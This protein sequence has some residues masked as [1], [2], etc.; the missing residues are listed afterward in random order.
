[1]QTFIARLLLWKLI[2]TEI[3]VKPI[4]KVT[5]LQNL[6]NFSSQMALT[7]LLAVLIANLDRILVLKLLPSEDFGRYSLSLTA[8]GFLQLAIQPFYRSFFPKFSELYAKNEIDEL[9]NEYFFSNK[10]L[11]FSLIALSSIFFF[12]AHDL[13]NLWL[14]KVDINLVNTFRFLIIGM[15]LSGLG[16]LPAAFQQAIG[17]PHLHVK[18]MILALICGIPITVIFINLF[19]KKSGL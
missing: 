4:F 12:F 8:T 16:W 14:N 11:S 18:M 7:S 3:T 17:W 1:M 15:L 2:S 10:L 13:F 5:I 9:E 6:I 19:G